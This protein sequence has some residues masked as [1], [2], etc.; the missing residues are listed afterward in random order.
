MAIFIALIFQVLFVLFAM[1]INVAL[2]VH[3]KINL[4]N[5]VDLAAYYAAERQAEMLNVIAHNNYVIRQAWKLLAWRYRVLGSMG[6]EKNPSYA[7]PVRLGSGSEEAYNVP[8]LVC[9]T[10]HSN[11]IEVPATQNLCNEPELKIPALP[12]PALIAGF[13]PINVQ[14]VKLAESL[15]VSFT[16]ACSSHGAYNWWYAMS[17]LHSFRLEQRYRRILMDALARNLGRKDFIDLNGQPVSAGAFQTYVRNLTYANKNSQVSFEVLNSLEGQDPATW[18]PPVHISPTI[19]YADVEDNDACNAVSTLIKDL[20]RRAQAR[21]KLL[22]QNGLNAGPLLIWRTGEAPPNDFYSMTIGVEKNPWYLAYVGVRATTAPRQVFFPFGPNLQMQARAFA[23]PFGGRIGPWYGQVWP[24]GS[25]QSAGDRIDPLIAPRT[26][27]DGLLDSPDDLT[28]LPNYSRFPG[29]P[30]GLTSR[31]ALKAINGLKNTAI[32]FKYYSF[33]NVDYTLG[34]ADDPLAWDYDSNKIPEIRKMELAAIA[35]DLFDV[36]YYSIEPNYGANYYP[37]LLLHRQQLGIPSDFQIRG[38]I[39]NHS[40]DIQLQSVQDVLQDRLSKTGDR[41]LQA[42]DAFYFI[43][44]K[45]NLLTGWAPGL[46]AMDYSFPREI[47][48]ECQLSDD[49][50]KVKNPG[51]CLAKGGRTGYSVRMISRQAL[52]SNAHKVGGASQ[53][54]G[55]FVNN[56][57]VYGW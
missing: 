55:A 19:T 34:G 38:D 5:A 28:R 57:Q 48:G 30:L 46:E 41:P 27:A 25:K 56:P 47:F 31:L 29:D 7:H 52:L 15:R 21:N 3:D 11:W 10:Y 22:D 13:L 6:V 42:S 14:V 2:V 44:K 24:A 16:E 50:H 36:S 12:Q 8:P 39:G 23:S 18:L 20:P 49:D 17:I 45:A 1:T 40:P 51:S 54:A 53:P 33:I 35:P 32:S 37:K 26:R 9:V 4:Q 43:R